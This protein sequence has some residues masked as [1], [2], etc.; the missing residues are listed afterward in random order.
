METEGRGEASS[1]AD[2]QSR[3][4]KGHITN[5]YLTDSDGE[6]TEDHKE[7]Y[8][9]TS[10]HFKDKAMKKVTVLSKSMQDLVQ[11]LKDW[12]WKLNSVQVLP[13]SQGNDRETKL[14]YLIF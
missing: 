6:A 9:K 14:T 13:G 3:C 5:I 10:K 7:L 2:C 8:D 4:M 12:L 1:S 11:I